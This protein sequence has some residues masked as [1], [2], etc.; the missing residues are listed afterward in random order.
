MKKISILALILSFCFI[1]TAC[2]LFGTPKMNLPDN[3]TFYNDD[4][5]TV[6]LT[7]GHVS[8]QAPHYSCK[9]EDFYYYYWYLGEIQKVPLQSQSDIT[10]KKEYQGNK[11]T[12]SFSSTTST[13][14]SISNTISEA[15]SKCNTWTQS[16][17]THLDISASYKFKQIN[18]LKKREHE[19][20]VAAEVGYAYAKSHGETTEETRSKSI[21]KACETIQTTSET[22][23]VSFDESFPHGWYRYVLFGNLNVYASLIYDIKEKTFYYDCA[24][25]IKNIIG[26]GFE[27]TDR[28][29]DCI[30]MDKKEKL[31]HEMGQIQN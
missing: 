18:E 25:S 26:Y 15:S 5:Y 6:A 1:F 24:E 11:Y 30:H 23:T 14:E 17:N 22:I 12:W 31:Q 7:N 19:V 2:D 9:D 28:I 4:T 16:H 20:T 27:Y 8:G 3:V 13:G 10:N 29:D 21:S